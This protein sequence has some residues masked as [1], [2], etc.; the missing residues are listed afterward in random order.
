MKFVERTQEAI[1]A[2]KEEI[3]EME[4]TKKRKKVWGFLP[5][6]FLKLS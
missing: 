1:E 4:N 2:A 3:K 5:Y 6:F